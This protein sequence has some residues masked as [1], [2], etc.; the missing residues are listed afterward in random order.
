M[1]NLLKKL[2]IAFDNQ[3]IDVEDIKMEKD[4]D[5]VYM[6]VNNEVN[7]IIYSTKN[8]NV[9][10]YEV[11]HQ[12]FGKIYTHDT[13]DDALMDLTDRLS[14]DISPGDFLIE[15]YSSVKLIVVVKYGLKPLYNLQNVDTNELEFNCCLEHS[16]LK[17]YVKK[18]VYIK[19]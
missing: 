3:D 19:Q 15:P 9:K 14:I 11:V 12:E 13:L 4:G 18:G 8:N 10:S 5:D 1:N 7:L 16:K 6:T 2:L 17:E